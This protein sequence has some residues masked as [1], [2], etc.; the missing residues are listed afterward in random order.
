M[1]DREE[2]VR[3]SQVI[4][5]SNF[6]FLSLHLTHTQAPSERA[7][8]SFSAMA[9]FAGEEI[10]N[11]LRHLLAAA[12]IFL[13]LRTHSLGT[14]ASRSPPS[15]PNML[16]INKRWVS[17]GSVT[18]A[19]WQTRKGMK[20][21]VKMKGRGQGPLWSP[22]DHTVNGLFTQRGMEGRRT[23]SQ[24]KKENSHILQCLMPVARLCNY[25][26]LSLAPSSSFISPPSTSPSLCLLPADLC[27]PPWNHRHIRA[28]NRP[29]LAPWTVQTH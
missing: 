8:C 14:P 26:P 12:C 10:W 18:L 9:C 13:F 7:L 20:E 16:L 1:N 23:W 11:T 15:L 29:S 27:Q 5:L 28:S 24:R 25:S 17:G 3:C 2:V 6:L 4:R 19:P 21:R 22:Q